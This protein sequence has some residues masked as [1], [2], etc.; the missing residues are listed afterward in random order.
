MG[1]NVQM[2]DLTDFHI[3]SSR[4]HVAV[5][6]AIEKKALHRSEDDRHRATYSNLENS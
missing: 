5:V 2:T 4:E 3:A 6:I 1:Q